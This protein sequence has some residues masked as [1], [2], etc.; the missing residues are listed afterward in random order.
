VQDG[1]KPTATVS[2]ERARRRYERRLRLLAWL[3]LPAVVR[4]WRLSRA[5]LWLLEPGP[6]AAGVWRFAQG[7]GGRAALMVWAAVTVPLI[8][9]ALAAPQLLPLYELSGQ[10]GRANGWSYQAATDYSLPL[11]NLL[12]LV[13]PF[14]FRDGR[15]GGWSLW[16]PWEVTYY[17]GVVPLALAVLGVAYGRRREVLFFVP[18]VVLAT[19]LALGDYSP[20]N[21]YAH[22]W[23]LPGVNLTRAPARFS[24]LG[25]LGIA[26]LAGFG[27]QALWEHL[28]PG[29][30]GARR[31]LRLLVLWMAGLVAGLAA[32]VWHLITWRAW[33]EREPLWALQLI[34][35]Q[36]LRLRRDPGVVDSAQQVYAGL[37]QSLDLSNRL[38]AL[39]LLLLA[40]LLLLAVC[41]S[42]LRRAR[43]LWQGLLVVL[44]AVDLASFARE[45]HGTR[46]IEAIAEVGPAG[47]FLAA[48]PGLHRIVT[49][50]GVKEPK[51]NK[52]LP[53]DVSE[54]AAYDPLE[55]SRHRVF[56]GATT[57]VDNWLLDLLGVRFRLLPEDQPG[58]PSYRQTAFNP[59]H[60]L[61]SGGAFNPS[62]RGAWTVGAEQSDELRVVSVL[63]GAQAVS[64]GEPVG[65]WVLTDTA[66]IEHSVVMLAGRDTAEWTYDDPA[67]AARPA[68]GRARVAFGFDLPIALPG[69]ARQVNLYYA[70]FP[71]ADR[72][73]VR[74]A[75]FRQLLPTGRMQVFGFGLFN[76]DRGLV[77]Q[78]FEREKYRVAFQG[79]GVLVQENRAAFPR[80]FAVPEAIVAPSAEEAL[81]LMAH[82]PI[83]P[84]R[85]VVLEDGEADPAAWPPP[86]PTERSLGDPVG[87]PYGEVRVVE[88]ESALVSV[89]AASNGGYLVLADAYY[90]GWKATVDGEDSPIYR[91]N[92]LFRAVVLPPGRHLVQFR[93]EPA[94]FETGATIARLSLALLGLALLVTLTP[95]GRVTRPGW[96]RTP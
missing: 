79:G 59:Q 24:Y 95:V 9:M 8:G 33:L 4:R 41:W 39:P 81:V 76:R 27:S 91:A 51:P 45:Y 83:Q 84:R 75:E 88:Y 47:R 17:A 11:P 58:L 55:L 5:V 73:A 43:A 60:P 61:V 72:P 71:L 74:R 89:E 44:V 96:I 7:V 32:A 46:T 67:L 38:T 57:Y 19:L 2:R 13:F 53:W 86:R 21:L 94:S 6:L 10:S 52:L 87:A 34:D 15:G 65:E 36:Y 68:H 62:G 3:R 78:F 69:G 18:L 42:E 54:A 63:E 14:F 56:R 40:A 31:R 50:P 77:A 25:V 29:P 28:R 48:Q 70:A 23:N 66:G 82:G 90:P 92:Y 35:E 30:T 80:A 37:S 49:D 1:P 22:V 16:Q 64:D 20:I 93:Y 26:T 85:Q 12:T